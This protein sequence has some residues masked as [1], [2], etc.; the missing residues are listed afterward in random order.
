MKH[1][2]L[3][4]LLLACSP[5]LA[6]SKRIGTFHFQTRKN[7]YAATVLFRVRPFSSNKSVYDP[8]VGNMVN[9]RKAYGAETTPEAE[10]LLGSSEKMATLLAHFSNLELISNQR[11]KSL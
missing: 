7:G 6:R 5:T 4:L 2:I 9:G 8:K 10:R 11:H 1:A 3:I